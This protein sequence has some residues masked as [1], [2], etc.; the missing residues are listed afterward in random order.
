MK[1][2]PTTCYSLKGNVVFA[3]ATALFFLLFVV[4]YSPAFGSSSPIVERW[5]ENGDFCIAIVTAIVL[6]TMTVSRVLM[7]VSHR[8]HHLSEVEYFVWQLCELAT[9]CLFADLFLSLFFHDRFFALLPRILAIGLALAIYPYVVYWIT[10]ELLESNSNL[11]RLM[12]EN[13][14]R[15]VSD[16][17]PTLRFPDENGNVKLLLECDKVVAIESDGNYVTVCYLDESGLVRFALRNTMKN[18]EAL[19]AGTPI[20]RCH[21]SYLVNT[22]KIRLLRKEPQGFVAEMSVVGI[23]DIPVSKSY[24]ASIMQRF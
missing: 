10:V 6:A 4:I 13:E 16:G 23:D 15:R 9:V 19:C 24:A 7:V 22:A 1:N 21:R 14:S 3:F 20:A 17:N 12:T 2:I 8:W 5:G 11:L 18:M